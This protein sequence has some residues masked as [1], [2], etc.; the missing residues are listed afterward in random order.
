M[1]RAALAPRISQ[2]RSMPRPV[3]QPFAVNTAMLL[4]TLAL[5]LVTLTLAAPR[6]ISAQ[7]QPATGALTTRAELT[8]AAAR[9]DS[10]A[11]AGGSDRDENVR[12]A[13]E[14]R[15]RLKAGDF[16]PGDRIVLVYE[17]DADHRDTLV[18]RAG[19]LVDM[20]WQS[21]INVDGV[22][23]SEVHAL[24]AA[25]VYRFV[26]A[27]R[28]DVTPLVRLGVLGE[29][30][31]PGY[32]AFSSDMPV[33]D[34]LM[35]AGGPTSLADMRRTTVRRFGREIKSPDE[36]GRAISSGLTLDQFGLSA[37]DELV[38]GQRRQSA[39]NPLTTTIGVLASVVTA[40]VALNHR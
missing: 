25:E 11:R 30:A 9:A 36:T 40:Y 4:R 33:T 2:P 16:R 14:I 31:R 34:A 1:T 20:P 24:V 35:S 23:R 29:V 7:Q 38:I 6:Q 28:V 8:A 5:S 22:L 27:E 39:L 19:G 15:Q 32:F 18:V 10:A 17:T 13:A 21:T 3:N 12:L 26:K 37:G